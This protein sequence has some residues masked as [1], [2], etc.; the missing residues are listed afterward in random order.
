MSDVVATDVQRVK[1]GTSKKAAL[2]RRR[3]FVDAYLAKGEN[4]TQAYMAVFGP[5]SSYDN[6]AVAASVLLKEPK[7]Q[8]LI[9]Q[10]RAE[11][12]AKF[13]L[14][15]DRVYLEV[16]RVAYFNP[17]KLVDKEGRIIPLH[18][19]DDDTA[20]GLSAIEMSETLPDGT[21]R[22]VRVRPHNKVSA[23]D[24]AS[25]ILKLYDRPPPVAPDAEPVDL[26]EATRKLAFM[27]ERE[28]VF[29]ERDARPKPVQARKKIKLTL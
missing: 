20:A 13:G 19:L 29:A 24:T 3:L 2:Q 4:A 14:T 18:E 22:E 12:R 16:G 23:L 15:T 21:V 6:Q 1:R 17:K 8:Q 9:E 7:V 10:R 28:A 5:G 26:R 25:K 11:L 27:L